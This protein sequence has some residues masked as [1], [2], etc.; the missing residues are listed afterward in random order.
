MENEEL[1]VGTEEGKDM[2]FGLR[3]EDI[4]CQFAEGPEG[5]LME[6]MEG[7]VGRKA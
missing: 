3:V 6:W 7:E 2:G 1:R 4:L 5:G